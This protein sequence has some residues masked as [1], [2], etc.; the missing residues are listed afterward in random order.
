MWTL[1]I[2]YWYYEGTKYSELTASTDYIVYQLC[3][4]ED[5]IKIEGQL[6][7]NGYVEFDISNVPEGVYYVIES[8]FDG[9]VPTEATEAIQ[10]S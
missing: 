10:I 2:G 5:V 6:T 7:Q 4:Q 3:D 8:G 9:P 1:Q